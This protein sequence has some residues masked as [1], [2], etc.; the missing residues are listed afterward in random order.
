MV[1]WSGDPDAAVLA[2]MVASGKT[3]DYFLSFSRCIR[4]DGDLDWAIGLGSAER[5][6]CVAEWSELGGW[7]RVMFYRARVMR[8]IR[9]WGSL[10]WEVGWLFERGKEVAAAAKKKKKHPQFS[11]EIYDIGTLN[12][13]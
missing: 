7:L 3:R 6:W 1:G 13:S 9:C 5:F 11:E 8:E 10:H 2:I 4:Q 12:F